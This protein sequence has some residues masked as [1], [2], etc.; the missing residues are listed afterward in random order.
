MALL[1]P[2]AA[3][4]ETAVSVPRVAKTVAPASRV[5]SRG[6]FLLPVRSRGAFARR[7]SLITRAAAQQ[8]ETQQAESA[9]SPVVDDGNSSDVD[10]SKEISKV[11]KKTATTFAPRAS[12]KSKNP[13]VPGS[14]LY[15]IF[16]AQA[17]L[18]AALGGLLSFNL[19]FPS[20]E[21]DIWRLMGMWSIWMFTIPSLRARNSS[22]KEKTALNCL[23]L[24]HPAPFFTLPLT[25][26]P[27][28]LRTSLMP[29]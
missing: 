10:V 3:V 29:L 15:T 7:S 12:T 4:F 19:L 21:P 1:A 23:S 8:P 22:E 13:A 28:L 2:A 20:D 9:A 16:E 24:V 6:V 25:Q 26:L 11:V 18:S 27:P 14:T 5:A 17:Y